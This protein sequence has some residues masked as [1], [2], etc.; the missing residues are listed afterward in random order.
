LFIFSDYIFVF[1][2]KDQN[3]TEKDE[4]EKLDTR[5]ETIKQRLKE[6]RK[7]KKNRKSS[8]ES[9]LE[10]ILNFKIN[11]IILTTNE[12]YNCIFSKTLS[13][14]FEYDLQII[15]LSQIFILDNI[16]RRKT[17]TNISSFFGISL[18]VHKIMK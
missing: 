7:E 2:G 17:M 14:L 10:A 4:P 16:W 6:N 13:R 15:C 9:N 3:Q 18:H 11:S 8:K 5:L 1:F 12:D